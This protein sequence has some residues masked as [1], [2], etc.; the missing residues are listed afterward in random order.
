MLQVCILFSGVYFS[1]HWC[2][3]CRGFTP[4]LAEFYKA[5]NQD[6]KRFE[7]VFA[8]SDRDEESFKEYFKEMPWL[9]I[10]FSENE[11]KQKAATKY[12]IR[13]IPT[14][15]ILK[16]NGEMLSNE[17]RGHVAGSGNKWPEQWK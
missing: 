15:I 8:S 9:A 13:G 6:K 16:K 4:Q 12:G 7:V 14:L 3:P 17:G 10:P 1:A 2:P 11:T 5:V